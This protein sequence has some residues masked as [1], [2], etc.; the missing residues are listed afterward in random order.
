MPYS[1]RLCPPRAIALSMLF[2]CAALPT[3]GHEFWLS[4][5]SYA[6][7][8]GRLVE[9]RA[10][11]GT[12]FRGEPQPWSPAH[13][14]R[15][16]ARTDRVLDLTPAAAAGDPSWARFAPSEGGGALVAFESGFTSIEMPA[17]AFEAYLTNE[18]LLAPLAARK[19]DRARGAG[20]ERFR[21]CA[22][23]WLAGA[24]GSRACAPCG[25]PLE[26]VPLR[27]PGRT[28]V[29]RVRV[30]WQGAPLPG[31]LVKTWN[32][33][34][35]R[36]GGIPDVAERDSA[37]VSARVVTDA[38]GEAVLSCAALGEWLVS[39]VHMEPSRDSAQADWESTWASLSFVRVA[40]AVAAR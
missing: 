37:S 26:I 31:A 8:P 29:L 20:R 27:E 7:S 28:T 38:H 5:T 15:F 24:D 14:V 32:A 22:K 23:A 19:R 4:P 39:V 17:A 6:A 36:A 21:R 16:T 18:G 30:L 13:S 2:L 40:N 12:G 11:A 33:P 10:V 25:L 1:R 35:T 9:L 34:V 3:Q